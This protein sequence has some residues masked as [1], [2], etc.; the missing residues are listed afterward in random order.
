[1]PESAIKTRY[2]LEVARGREP[3]RRYTLDRGETAVGNAPWAPA[4]LSLAD[5]EG[6][7]PRRMAPR[8]AVILLDGDRLSIR[9]LESP[10]G[11][12]VNRQR[13]F[14][15]QERVLVPG[16]VIQVGAVQLVARVEA[17]EKP[18]P[19]PPPP[20]RPAPPPKPA[21]Q[22]RPAPAPKPATTP[23]PVDPRAP[24]GAPCAFADGASCRTWDDFLTLSAQRWGAVRDE[25]ASGRIGEHLRR[26]GRVDLLPRREPGWSADDVLDDWLGRLPTSRPS[27]PE[28]DVL[29]NALS[30]PA[31]VA[32][33][34]TRR[35]FRVANVGYRLLRPSVAVEPRPGFEGAIRLAGEPSGPIV[36]EAEYVVEVA[37]PEGVAGV[38]LGAV[39][40]KAGGITKR[41]DVRIEAPRIDAVPDAPSA[42]SPGW[43]PSEPIGAGLSGVSAWRRLWA[44]PLGALAFRGLV[45]LGATLSFASGDGGLNLVGAA[46]WP[47]LAGL[48]V[49]WGVG[50]KGGPLDAIASAFAG[51]VVALLA[52]A[53]VFATIQ[54][55]EAFFGSPAVS[56]L[57]L[58]FGLAILSLI[59]FPT[60]RTE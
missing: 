52:A 46:T 20:P 42:A 21:G 1:M 22:A 13:L 30:V 31:N 57:A 23:K 36:D 40:V 60:R 26:V 2:V 19:K 59:A 8:Q 34:V 14:T 17:V 47:T 58:G 4:F 45:G 37:A 32:G 33:A 29:T 48:V 43:S 44:F 55:V 41:I 39:V 5:Q 54:S 16:D 51:A 27:D 53:V 35:S 18:A 24:L 12:F 50:M 11:T 28:L 7:S 9:D 10:G 49:G 15:N 38:A 3:G 6:D 25:L 56:A